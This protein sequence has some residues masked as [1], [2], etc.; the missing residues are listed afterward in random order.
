NPKAIVDY[1]TKRGISLKIEGEFDKMDRV[2]FLSKQYYSSEAKNTHFDVL[3]VFKNSIICALPGADKTTL[4][5]LYADKFINID[6]YVNIELEELIKIADKVQKYIPDY[7]YNV[8]FRHNRDKLLMKFSDIKKDLK[9]NKTYLL[10]RVVGL[11]NNYA[12]YP[13]IHT[14]S[15]ELQYSELLNQ[16]FDL[17]IS[18]MEKAIQKTKIILNEVDFKADFLLQNY[19]NLLYCLDL[20]FPTISRDTLFF[21]PDIHLI[22]SKFIIE[23]WI[24]QNGG[25]QDSLGENMLLVKESPF[26]SIISLQKF[27]TLFGSSSL[28][29]SYLMSR[30]PKANIKY[31]TYLLYNKLFGDILNIAWPLLADFNL[32]N[33]NTGTIIIPLDHSDSIQKILDCLKR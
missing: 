12:Y 32:D 29:L 14:I 1:F 5:D 24:Y 18:P 21:D 13:D 4:K 31:L 15:N 2:E 17:D 26:A 33:V 22:C 7:K 27:F 28:E 30:D 9:K 6:N 11:A 25:C 3:E 19:Q 8:A 16:L 23:R 20:D 10:E